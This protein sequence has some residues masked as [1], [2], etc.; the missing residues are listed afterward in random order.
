[1]CNLARTFTFRHTNKDTS[2]KAA[3]TIASMSKNNRFSRAFENL[4]HFVTV[5][6]KKKQ[7]HVLCKTWTHDVEKI[8]S[9]QF[10]PLTLFNPIKF[11]DGWFSFYIENLRWSGL[12]VVAIPIKIFRCRQ[13]SLGL[14]WTRGLNCCLDYFIEAYNRLLGFDAAKPFQKDALWIYAYLK[15]SQHTVARGYSRM[16][17]KKEGGKSDTLSDICFA[18]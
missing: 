6:C 2:V 18:K 11:L 8:Y 10:F 4:E 3:G 16:V 17:C 1:M 14:H 13:F 5:L 15:C 7:I 12:E 9:L